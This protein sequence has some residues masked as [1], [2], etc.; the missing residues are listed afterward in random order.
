MFCDERLEILFIHALG[1]QQLVDPYE[2]IQI[3]IERPEWC[4]ISTHFRS[5]HLVFCFFVTDLILMWIPVRS[6]ICCP[7][8]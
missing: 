3:R 7:V 8:L 5:Y 2:F 1:F 6:I 4:L